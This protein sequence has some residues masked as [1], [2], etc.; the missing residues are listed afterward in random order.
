[1]SDGAD[2]PGVRSEGSRQW[3]VGSRQYGIFPTAYCLRPTALLIVSWR[4]GHGNASSHLY[5][6]CRVGEPVRFN[7]DRARRDGLERW[8][9][10][11][12]SAVRDEDLE[13]SF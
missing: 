5:W 8:R 4:E 7:V 10:S 11:D 3:A 1:M 12:Q 13:W 6:A 2:F 9:L